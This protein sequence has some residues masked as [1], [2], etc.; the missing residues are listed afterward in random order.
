VD[1]ELGFST[2]AKTAFNQVRE[3]EN[4]RKIHYRDADDTEKHD[5]NISLA[6]MAIIDI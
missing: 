6:I 2:D 5:E 4:K 3:Q 1:D